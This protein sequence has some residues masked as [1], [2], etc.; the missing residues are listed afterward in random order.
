MPLLS[1]KNTDYNNGKT[2]DC[3]NRISRT[4]GECFTK[5]KIDFKLDLT[6]AGRSCHLLLSPL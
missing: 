2:G 3:R 4:P 5:T 6:M 1:F